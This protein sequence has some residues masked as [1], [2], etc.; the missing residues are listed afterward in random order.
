VT[1]RLA[2]ADDNILGEHE[3]EPGFMLNLSLIDEGDVSAGLL[4]TITIGVDPDVSQTGQGGGGDMGGPG[5]G[6]PGG[7][8]EGTPP[9]M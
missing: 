1:T 3:E 2:N 9:D 6:G 7:P 8:P 5:D 4:G